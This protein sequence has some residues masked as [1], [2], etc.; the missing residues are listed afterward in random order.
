MFLDPKRQPLLPEIGLIGLVPDTWQSQWQPRHQVL[1]RLAKYFNIVWASPAPFWRDALSARAAEKK[2]KFEYD[3]PPGF[4]LNKHKLWLPRF[5]KP[6]WLAERTARLRLAAARQQLIDRHCKSVL[7]YL[8]R[9]EYHEALQQVA[10]DHA[11][12]HID[13]EYSFSSVETPVSPEETKLITESDAVII[14]SPAL[15]EKK[16]HLNPSTYFV[17]NGV[18]FALYSQPIPEPPDIAAI[19]PPRIGYTGNVKKQLDWDLITGLVEKHPEWSFVFV[20]QIMAHPGLQE[21]VE[22]LSSRKN[23]HFLGG[24]SVTALAAYPQHFDVCIMPYCN[25]NYTKFIYPLK[26]HEYL[27]GGQPVVGTR[28]RS[29]E[30]FEDSITLATNIEEWSAGITAGLSTQAASQQMRDAR[31]AVARQHDWDLLVLRIARIMIEHMD[32]ISS[33]Q[34]KEYLAKLQQAEVHSQGPVTTDKR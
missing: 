13:D 16:G 3:L 19:K 5:H 28:I 33:T 23:V 14:H 15:L 1:V 34:K 22:R 29:L 6:R 25:D 4:I 32:S 21:I 31:Q 27:G 11:F 30:D 8:W 12:Y 7:L 17:P 9:P 2:S 26:L 24:K 20:G 10:H 18:D